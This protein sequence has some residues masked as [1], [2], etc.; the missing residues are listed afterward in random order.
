MVWNFVLACKKCNSKKNDKIPE[1]VVMV[2][3]LERN[4]RVM[5]SDNAFI[6]AEMKGYSAETM[7]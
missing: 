2:K 1:K 4:E 7:M 5:N 3:I 6:V